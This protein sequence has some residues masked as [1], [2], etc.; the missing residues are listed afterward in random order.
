[1][2]RTRTGVA[3]A[4]LTTTTLLLAG[5]GGA[6]EESDPATPADVL[7]ENPVPTEDSLGPTDI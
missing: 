2:R 7:S 6:S 4:L 3:A 1:M 5:C